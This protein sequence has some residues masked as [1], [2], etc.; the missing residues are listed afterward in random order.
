MS[1]IG[2]HVTASADA[3][4]VIGVRP[5]SIRQIYVSSKLAC[6]SQEK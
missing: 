6:K 4:H 1:V 2:A 3:V 5:I